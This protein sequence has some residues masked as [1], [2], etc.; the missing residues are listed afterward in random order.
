MIALPVSAVLKTSRIPFYGE[1]RTRIKKHWHHALEDVVTILSTGNTIYAGT[2]ITTSWLCS[3]PGD[4]ICATILFRDGGHNHLAYNTKTGRYTEY[5]DHERGMFS[6]HAVDAEKMAGWFARYW[7]YS[8]IRFIDAWVRDDLHHSLQEISFLSLQQ[9][10]LPDGESEE[11]SWKTWKDGDHLHLSL[12]FSDK[13][14][15]SLRI[16]KDDPRLLAQGG[17]PP[18]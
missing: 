16:R 1:L 12:W 10:M 2:A 11:G 5:S 14:S 15:A 17:E 7:E 4:Y 8:L 3:L 9:E 6:I 18:A 13:T